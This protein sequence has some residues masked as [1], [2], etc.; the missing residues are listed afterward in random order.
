MFIFY[1]HAEEIK[2][3]LQVKK[4]AEKTE[5]VYKEMKRKRKYYE[6]QKTL[7]EAYPPIFLF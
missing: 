4:R 5:E 2:T 3:K 6:G 7:S 1:F